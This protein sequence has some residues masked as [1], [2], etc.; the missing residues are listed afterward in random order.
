MLLDPVLSFSVRCADWVCC[1]CDAAL[2]VS[3]LRP[4]PSCFCCCCCP[5]GGLACL[6]VRCDRFLWRWVVALLLA[7]CLVVC[8]RGCRSV[9]PGREVVRVSRLRGLDWGWGRCGVSLVGL[10]LLGVGSASGGS[11]LCER[12]LWLCG[13]LPVAGVLPRWRLCTLCLC[14]CCPCALCCRVCEVLLLWGCFPACVRTCRCCCLL[15]SRSDWLSRGSPSQVRGC[16]CFRHALPSWLG[17]VL[18]ACCPLLPRPG[19]LPCCCRVLLPSLRP[20]L[21]SAMLVVLPVVVGRPTLG[22]QHEVGPSILGHPRWVCLVVVFVPPRV[23]LHLW[24]LLPKGRREPRQ[25]DVS[26]G[27]W[28]V[29][30]LLLCCVRSKAG[31][32]GGCVELVCCSGAAWLPRSLVLRPV[33][34]AFPSW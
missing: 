11:P 23:L 22:K 19:I 12:G 25:R 2:P 7:F 13:G 30:F 34:Q 29:A 27:W 20:L 15:C 5:G 8:R 16:G 10:L 21:L 6:C 1:C 14:L 9:F 33:L 3:F 4:A 18:V 31:R 28:L 24:R 32:V 26:L 17:H